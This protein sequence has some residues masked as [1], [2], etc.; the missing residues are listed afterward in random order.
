MQFHKKEEDP[1]KDRLASLSAFSKLGATGLHELEKARSLKVRLWD[2]IKQAL[3]LRKHED[4]VKEKD[5]DDLAFEEGEIG[6]SSATEPVL[7]AV[8]KEAFPR[9]NTI[10]QGPRRL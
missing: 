5:D 2:K 4:W 10:V 1:F 8:Q 6:M 7:S 3:P 9:V